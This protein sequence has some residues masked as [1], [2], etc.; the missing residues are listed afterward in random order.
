MIY[1]SIPEEF[2][3][4]VIKLLKYQMEDVQVF[5]HLTDFEQAIFDYDRDKFE[6]FL[7]WLRNQ[8]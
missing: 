4:V 7:S 5:I 3:D 8:P 6:E 1:S 2:S